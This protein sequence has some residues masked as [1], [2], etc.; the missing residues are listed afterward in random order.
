MDSTWYLIIFIILVLLAYLW[1]SGD[2]DS[3][4]AQQPE[5]QSE[6]QQPTVGMG[7]PGPIYQEVGDYSEDG[8]LQDN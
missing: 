4:S 1:Y 3:K 7:E 8:D 5:K 6:T 2:S